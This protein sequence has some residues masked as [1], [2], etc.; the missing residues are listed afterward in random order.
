MLEARSLW[1]KF[2]FQLVQRGS[3]DSNVAVL[4]ICFSPIQKHKGRVS[5]TTV[6]RTDGSRR[7]FQLLWVIWSAYYRLRLSS[8]YSYS[9]TQ[10]SSPFLQAIKHFQD[11]IQRCGTDFSHISLYVSR[12]F[13]LVQTITMAWPGVFFDRGD[14]LR[15]ISN[16]T[17][18]PHPRSIWS[19]IFYTDFLQ[20]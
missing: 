7:T 13:L 10:C 18:V 15:A 4:T 6:C 3:V 1:N 5:T 2:R 20:T 19:F 11:H 8:R 12:E 17:T 14:Q 16:L 9:T